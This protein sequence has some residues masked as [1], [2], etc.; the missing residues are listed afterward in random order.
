MKFYKNRQKWII[1]SVIIL[2]FLLLAPSILLIMKAL[3]TNFIMQYIDF[4]NYIQNTGHNLILTRIDY[5]IDSS[6]L[7]SNKILL[8]YPLFLCISIICSSYSF[9]EDIVVGNVYARIWA[10][11]YF[12]Q[13]NTVTVLHSSCLLNLSILYN[14]QLCTL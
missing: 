14:I 3:I 6:S 12:N 2:N 13:F 10:L 9:C 5:Q 1:C 8:N 7:M 4:K 11:H